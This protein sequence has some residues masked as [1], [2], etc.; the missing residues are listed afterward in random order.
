MRVYSVINVFPSAILAVAAFFP[1][2]ASAPESCAETVLEPYA[3]TQDFEGGSLAAWASYPLWQDTAFD[4]NI[5]VNTIAPGDSNISLV[6]IVTPYTNV[7]NYAGAQKRFDAWMTPGSSVSLRYYLKTH[8]PCEFIKLRIAAGPDGKVDVTVPDPPVNRWV[9]L[10]VD[11]AGIIG[12]N[13]GLAGRDRIKVN[14]LAVLAKIPDADPAMP[15]Y[16]GLDDV[17]FTGARDMEFRFAEPAVHELTEFK[18]RVASRHYRRGDT[19]ALAGTWPLDAGRVTVAVTP[20]LDDSDVVHESALELRN[21]SWRLRPVRID[22]PEGMYIAALRA[23]RG[24]DLLSESRLSF[25]VAPEDIG[26]VHPRLWFDAGREAWIKER[27]NSSRFAGV[28]EDILRNAA[29]SREE[30]PVDG[31]HWD[32]DQ[33]PDEDALP[34]WGRWTGVLF[35]WGDAMYWNALEYRL[36]G[37]REAGEYARDVLLRISSFPNWDH[38]W[39]L[40]RGRYDYLRNGEL[41]QRVAL[42][43]DLTHDLM[44]GE[45]A[46]G[47][48]AAILKNALYG[49]FRTY[50]RDDM[51]TNDTSNWIAHV[52]GGALMCHAAVYGDAP[53][54]DTLE[55]WLS[56][57]FLKLRDFVTGTFTAGESYGEGMG[58]Y[59]TAMRALARSLPCVDNVFGIDFS[60]LMEGSYGEIVWSGKIADRVYFFYGDSGGLRPLDR[61]AWLLHKTHEPLLGWLYNYLKNDDVFYDVLYETEDVPRDDPYDENPVRVF[62]DI[63]NIVFKSGWEKDA[64]AFVMRAGPF[65]NHQHIDQGSFWLADRGEIFIEERHGSSYYSGPLYQSWYTQPV[66]HSTI[67]IDGNHQSQR[68]GDTKYIADGFDDHAFID[69]FL[70]GESAAFA[71]GDIGRLYWDKVDRLRRHVLFLKPSTLLMLDEA[72]PG[73]EGDVDVTLLYQTERLDDITAAADH[74]TIASGDALLHLMH[75][76]PARRAVERVETPHYLRTLQ[77]RQPLEREGMLTVTARTGGVPLVMANLL[78]TTA[79]GEGIDVVTNEGAGHVAGAAAGVDFAFTTGPGSVWSNAGFVTD[80][81]AV[82]WDGARV[83]AALATRFEQDGRPV[84]SAERPVTFERHA[85]RFRCYH[86]KAGTVRF[87]S[88][89]PPRKVVLNG[90]ETVGFTWVAESR[91]VALDAPAGAFSVEITV[92]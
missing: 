59:S 80:A 17:T 61:W 47:A 44:S 38:P 31:I 29:S 79:A 52:I 58:Y 82:T 67:L 34:V 33:F 48:R 26:G 90:S 81:L 25:I 14:T 23:Y 12:E 28:K 46:A 15:F 24:G 3:Y 55:P 83:F 91:T 51:V 19:L 6:Q 9:W 85:G 62:R 68:T 35:D 89:G 64:F 32:F 88:V 5:R 92:D 13:P 66:G 60:P 50:V 10:R 41:H 65:V 49:A 57:S 73:S 22:F 77:E 71:T 27:L 84:L 56:G 87:G 69:H 39:M 37:N 40:K 36:L 74:S 7:D 8:L 2:L 78:T 53:E 72:A 1:I 42:A 63:G 16:L 75:L 18:P 45:Q 30:L 76:A 4:Q 20:L 70:D 86:S 11:F 43:Y 54:T 21:G